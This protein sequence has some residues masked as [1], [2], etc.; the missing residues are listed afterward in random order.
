MTRTTD[1]MTRLDLAGR[2]TGEYGQRLAIPPWWR[3]AFAALDDPTIRELVLSRPRQSGKSQLLAA[4]AIT[5]VLLRPDAYVVMAA[6]SETQAAAIYARKIKKPL[7]RLLQ[8]RGTA[9]PFRKHVLITKRGIQLSNGSA[10]EVIATNAETSPGRSPT[11]LLLDEARDIR[12]DFYGAFVPSVIGAGGKL[13][14]ASTAG[15]PRGFFFDLVRRPT[16]ETWLHHANTNDNPH[17]DRRMMAFLER[18]LSAVMPA[19]ARRELRNEFTDDGTEFLPAPL[20]DAAVDETLGEMS[21]HEAPAFVMYDLSRKRD[22]TSRTV[23]LWEPPRRPEA[24]DHLVVAS[25][26]VWDP[27]MSPTGEVD[28]AEVR[29]DLDLL[30]QRFPNLCVVL[31]DEGAEAGALL[32]FARGRAPLALV[33]TGF[34]AT[35]ESNM[36]L[37][38]TLAARLHARTLSIPAHDRLIA[39]L[40]G[41]RQEQFAFGGRWRVLDS[42]RKFHRD[43]S[44]TLAG[45]CFAVEEVLA[46]MPELDVSPQPLGGLPV[47]EIGD[48]KFIE[49]ELFS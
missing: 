20:I 24:R 30:P 27:R 2:L 40:R 49:D 37:W 31:I 10:L 35:P 21:A 46:S 25:I 11:L 14:I 23:V 44:L 15:P 39:E 26:R 28:F 42:S 17:A 47:R 7:E 18:R 36:K 6:A 1:P 22:L 19:A 13:I 29:A 32:P 38:G 12:D 33:T 45:A 34:T 9:S 4:L 5:E 43:V 8:L 48:S 3:D 41:L 16:S